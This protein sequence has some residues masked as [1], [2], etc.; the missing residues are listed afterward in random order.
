MKGSV[1][2]KGA[3]WSYRIDL[4]VINGKRSQIERS[5][6]KTKKEAMPALDF[7][8]DEWH[9]EETVVKIKGV[10][11]YI[12]FIIYSETRFVLGF[13]LYPN[14]DSPQVEIHLKLSLCLIV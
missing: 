6:Y 7:N 4:G 11:H 12:W 1:R 13:Q 8:S 3:T 10:K 9:A 2:K 14:R 5:G